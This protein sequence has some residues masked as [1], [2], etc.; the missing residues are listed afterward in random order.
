MTPNTP[1][2]NQL[3]PEASIVK[4]VLEPL[5]TALVQKENKVTVLSGG[6]DSECKQG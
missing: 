5:K 2:D 4:M 6:I 3:L 1:P